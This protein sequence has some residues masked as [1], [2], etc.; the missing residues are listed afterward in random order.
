VDG[1]IDNLEELGNALGTPP[2][3]ASVALAAFER[4]RIE[5]GSHLL[6]DF[7]VIVYEEG[8]RRLTC[9]RDPLGQRPLF[10]GL[11][12]RGIVFGSEAQQIVRHPAISRDTNEGMIGE[13]LADHPS[14]V[15][16]TLWKYVYRLP[17]AHALEISPNGHEVRRYWN[18][19]PD[20]RVVHATPDEYAE[21]FLD[22]FT[23]A[24]ECRLRMCTGQSANI[25]VL[26]SGGI[27][28][29]SI[30][31]VAQSLRQRSS[32]LPVHAFSATFPDRACDESAF[33]D[34]VVARWQLPATRT[35]VVLPTIDELRRDVDRY[36]DL[37]IS[38]GATANTLR[39]LAAGIGIDVLLTGCGGDDYFSGSPLR[40]A[41]M[42]GRGQV[43]RAARAAVNPL[44]SDRARRMLRPVFGARRPPQ[45]W[46]RSEFRDRV[47]LDERLAPAP[48]PAF[49]TRDQREMYRIVSGL[50]QIIGDEVEDRAAHA[51]G[52]LQRHPF[53]DRRVAEFGLALPPAQRFEHGHHKVVVRRALRDYLPP[54]VAARADKAEFSFTYVAALEQ[55]GS[56]HLLG[57]LR[58][59]EAG[60]VDGDVV[61][62]MHRRMI[63]LY[64]R[65]SDAYI[66]L[67]GPLWAVV[68]LEM[69]LE[70]VEAS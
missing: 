6:G 43:I 2:T 39:A 46:I 60:W 27:D 30:A 68:S 63:D 11:S 44:L 17:P 7:V 52:I 37:S 70:R 12:S 4:W 64:R 3:I 23:R 53:Y 45:P 8:E 14:T 57:K 58:S 29:S 42:I 32:G 26:L 33:I 9:V 56:E 47:N 15:A 66:E 36:L 35:A 40:L 28:S 51:A 18:F 13:Q 1:V 5:A 10:Y 49:P 67:T 50:S 31:S 59:E 54:V 55:L 62:D 38:P 24:V 65:G 19:D 25:G 22:L 48:L 61:R 20:S 16:E 41:D 21:H 34:A 69:W